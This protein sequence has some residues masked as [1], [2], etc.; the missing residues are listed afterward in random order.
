MTSVV[1]ARRGGVI[2]IDTSQYP[3]LIQ[4]WNGAPSTADLDAYFVE[5]DEIADHA[6]ASQT[7][8]CVVVTGS[9]NIAAGGRKYLGAWIDTVPKVRRERNLG[10]FVVIDSAAVR[11]ML[12]ALRWVSNNLDEVTPVP[13]EVEGIRQAKERLRL[14]PRTRGR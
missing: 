6:I 4:R 12:T 7:F 11:G 2:E 14:D 1:R 10:S 8:Y 9:L 5:A 13:T 3:L